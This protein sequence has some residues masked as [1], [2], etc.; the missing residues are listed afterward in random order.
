MAFSP[1]VAAATA[2]QATPQPFDATAM[3]QCIIA[4]DKL[5]SAE[6]AAV[7]VL[8]NG[9]YVPMVNTPGTGAVSLTATVP[10]VVLPGGCVYGC[11]KVLTASACGV[12]GTA[13][14]WP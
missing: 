5:A 10:S 14:L 12:F 13:V 11:T 6:T 7:L 2:A 4:A 3:S 9:T 8:V 1:I